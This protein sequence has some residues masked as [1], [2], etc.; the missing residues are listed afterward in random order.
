MENLNEEYKNLSELVRTAYKLISPM[1]YHDDVDRLT[2]EFVMNDSKKRPGCYLKLGQ[3]SDHTLFPICNRYGY[4]DPKMIQ[5]SLKLAKKIAERNVGHDTSTVILKLE[6][7]L[8]KYDKPV[9]NTMSQAVLKGKSTKEFNKKMNLGESM[10]PSQFQDDAHAVGRGVARSAARIAIVTAL[11][12]GIQKMIQKYS[13][14]K[15]E[16]TR[17]KL[18]AKIKK[19]KAKLKTLKDKIKKEKGNTKAKQKLEE[20]G[21]S[22][23]NKDDRAKKF[24]QDMYNIKDKAIDQ[25]VE[26]GVTKLIGKALAYPTSF[27]KALVATGGAIT[28][29]KGKKEYDKNKK[30]YN[31]KKKI[32]GVVAATAIVYGLK[33]LYDKYK[34]EKDPKKKLEIKS[35]INKT[36]AKIKTKKSIKEYYEFNNEDVIEILGEGAALKFIKMAA[37]DAKE[38]APMIAGNFTKSV[39]GSGAVVAAG[40]GATKLANSNIKKKQ[41]SNI[42][43]IAIGTAA[44]GSTALLIKKL[45]DKFKKE[46]D[47]KKKA[48]IKTKIL[49]AKKVKK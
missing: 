41:D 45:Y 46:K 9:P 48:E 13:E 14:S 38:F 21:N 47:P 10:Q 12:Y 23:L 18:K 19:D 24:V 29:Y 5:F 44:I 16:D 31:N 1:T 22:D 43:N 42:K 39:T 34:K 30:T 4:K 28:A 8:N 17:Y 6:K 26:E 33:K 37:K 36:K 49:K 20:W 15:D 7:L 11:Y 40:A 25:V 35:K 32:G 3:G 2:P 27:E